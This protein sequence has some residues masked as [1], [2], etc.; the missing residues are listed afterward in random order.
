MDR[1]IWKTACYLSAVPPTTERK[2]GVSDKP[3]P[4]LETNVQIFSCPIDSSFFVEWEGGVGRQI[5]TLY[6]CLKAKLE[7]L[8]LQEQN[9]YQHQSDEADAHITLQKVICPVL[10]ENL[11]WTRIPLEQANRSISWGKSAQ[12]NGETSPNIGWRILFGHQFEDG[13]RYSCW[14]EF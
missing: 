11:Y 1:K 9:W 12:S 3:N 7:D 8:N 2:V 5:V 14:V 4:S 6:L 10:N 13:T